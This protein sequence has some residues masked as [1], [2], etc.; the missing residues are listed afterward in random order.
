M[1]L[2]TEQVKAFSRDSFIRLLQHFISCIGVMNVVFSRK[3]PFLANASIVKPPRID[4]VLSGRKHMLYPNGRRIADERLPA[5]TVHYSPSWTCKLPLWDEVHE[6]SSIVFHRRFLR[7]T[8]IDNSVP[9]AGLEKIAHCFYHTAQPGSDEIYRLCAVLDSLAESPEQ[10]GAARCLIDGL[11]RMVLHDLE[12]DIPCRVSKRRLTWMRISNYMA[13]NFSQPLTRENVAK[14]HHLSP[15]YLS[16]LFNNESTESFGAH[17][18]RLRLE[19]AVR[20]LLDGNDTIEA[21][22]ERCGYLSSTCFIAAFRRNYGVSPGRYRAL[23]LNR[24]ASP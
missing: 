17:L 21:I 11:L 15:C 12:H 5:G 14:I 16:Q 3:S 9:S 1:G 18:R 24:A 6:M 22:S 7:I 10:H 13:D 2:F 23:H 19:Y 4:M 20:L 8:Y